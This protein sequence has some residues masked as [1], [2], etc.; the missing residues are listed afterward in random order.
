MCEWYCRVRAAAGCAPWRSRFGLYVWALGYWGLLVG[1]S[2]SVKRGVGPSRV[3]SRSAATRQQQYQMRC[4]ES[5]MQSVQEATLARATNRHAH[6]LLLP[7]GSGPLWESPHY[8]GQET[9]ISNAS[10]N[11]YLAYFTVW[12][13][14]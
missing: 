4:M 5:Q 3:A 9:W 10:C 14:A 13:K 6:I 2:A 12:R 11:R 7:S 1:N 8:G